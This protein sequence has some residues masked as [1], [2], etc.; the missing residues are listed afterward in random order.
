M[1][2]WSLLLGACTY[3]TK[4]TVL[5]ITSSGT[6]AQAVGFGLINW[7]IFGAQFL[8]IPDKFMDDMFEEKRTTGHARLVCRVAAGA[9]FT[10]IAALKE[11]PPFKALK[12]F[13]IANSCM[14]ILGPKNAERELKCTKKHI[15]P[16][17]ALALGSIVCALV[18]V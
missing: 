3:F 14:L 6:Y 17:A 8:A 7:G 11:L 10:S 2:T 4:Q 1:L 18:H 13:S 5:S 9:I 15:V 12:I 16:H